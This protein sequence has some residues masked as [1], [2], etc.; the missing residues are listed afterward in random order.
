M[1]GSKDLN[2][3]SSS[4]SALI[5]DVSNSGE[6]LFNQIIE[7]IKAMDSD[8]S[9]IIDLKTIT[10]DELRYRADQGPYRGISV[11]WILAAKNPKLLAAV[12]EQFKADFTI[13]DFRVMALGECKKGISMLWWLAVNP[14]QLF[15]EVW[16]QFKADFTLDDFRSMTLD[17]PNKG[18]SALWTLASSSPQM[19]SIVWEQFKA[20]FRLD[21]FRSMPLDGPNMGVSVLWILAETN[22][23]LFAAVW[24]Q[25]KTD[26]TLDDFR[27]T[28]A[29]GPNK[30]V[31]V[32]WSLLVNSSEIFPA[33]WEQLKAD[34]TLDDF[35]SMPLEGPNKGSTV[36]WTL[37]VRHHQVFAAIWEQ[38]KAE[39]TVNDFRGMALEGAYKGMSVLWLL[40][41][42]H[43]KIFA[44]VWEQFKAEFRFDDF[45]VI[46]L[47]GIY[48]GKS[49]LWVLLAKHPK[50]FA[51]VWEQFKVD[52][53][54][55]DF[56]AMALE[57]PF[58]GASLLWILTNALSRNI[59]FQNMIYEMLSQLPGIFST[60]DLSAPVH[61][62][63]SIAEL[64]QVNTSLDPKVPLLIHARNEF[65]HC[66]RLAQDS[67]SCDVVL[68]SDRLQELNNL[69]QIAHDAGYLNAFYDLGNFLIDDYPFEGCQAYRKVPSA[70]W[71]LKKMNEHIA[72]MAENF[73]F[74]AT[75]PDCEPNERINFLEQSLSCVL[76]TSRQTRDPVINRIAY[77]YLRTYGFNIDISH[78]HGLVSE[79]ML[80]FI[81]KDPTVERCI[82]VFEEVKREMQRED[83]LRV[84]K[85]QAR[86]L[87]PEASS[88]NPTSSSSSLELVS[89]DSTLLTQFNASGTNKRLSRDSEPGEPTD[90]KRQRDN[91]SQL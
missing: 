89:D 48:K 9:N 32:L 15:S 28:A 12:W 46:A 81:D 18:V 31:S 70:S 79:F 86:I 56:R 67:L 24:E 73:Y 25:F 40:L 87:Q 14:P 7:K 36:L 51:T 26:F 37:L 84:F 72:E 6:V 42:K 83:E 34:F 75:C 4:S 77:S 29:H 16:E 50:I 68:T 80:D 3:S 74:L 22:P 61:G 88:S 58:K 76:L 49:V 8:F 64:I 35:R 78:M 85:G 17:R 53:R 19:F 59:A 66:V 47:E 71:Y 11:L 23:K 57:G 41:A 55:D 2:A 82:K 63:P 45:R 1:I 69:A 13:E 27:S 60:E 52:F 20:E 65:F 5:D 90:C 21:D 10:L 91:R 38:F 44:T 54:L 62:K 33:V 43:P 39:F 30:G